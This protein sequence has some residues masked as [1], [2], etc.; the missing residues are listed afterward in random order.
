MM[1]RGNSYRSGFTLVE[2]VVVLFI[3]SV[4]SA[5]AAPALYSYIESGRQISRMNT[6][7]TLYL[8]A[9]SQLTLLRTAGMLAGAAEGEGLAVGVDDTKV[10]YKLGEPAD[11]Q[12]TGNEE[13]V[14]FISKPTGPAPA[15]LML[16]LLSPVMEKTVLNDAILIELNIKTGV[17]LSVFYRDGRDDG[18]SFS[19]AQSAGDAGVSGP[20]GMGAAGYEPVAGIRGRKQG[21]YGVQNTGSLLDDAEPM[22][23]NIYDSKDDGVYPDG[24]LSDNLLFVRI[25]IPAVFGGDDFT[26]YIPGYPELDKPFSPSLRIGIDNSFNAALGGAGLY[27]ERDPLNAGGPPGYSIIWILD[28]V[29][30]DTADPVFQ[31]SYSIGGN[32]DPEKLIT[33]G[34]VNN[35]SGGSAESFGKHPYCGAGSLGGRYSVN[36]AR[37]LYNIRYVLERGISGAAYIQGADIDLSKPHSEVTNFTPIPGFTGAYNGNCFSVSNLTVSATGDA[38]LFANIAA[39][40]EVRN[41]ALANASVSSTGGSAGAVCGEL[42]GVISGLYVKYGGDAARS[43]ITGLINSGGVAGAVSDGGR[44][45]NSAFISPA[46]F[47]HIGGLGGGGNAS[48]GSG[49]A[50]GGIAGVN[51]GSISNVLFLALAP[52]NGEGDIVPIANEAAG[53]AGN[54]YYLSGGAIRPGPDGSAYGP[55]PGGRADYNLE[56]SVGPGIGKSTWELYDAVNKTGGYPLPG[57]TKRAGLEA[58][59]QADSGD[60]A[61]FLPVYPYPFLG[62]LEKAVPDD[63]GWPIAGSNGNNILDDG[64]RQR[65]AG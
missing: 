65:E 38:G 50:A 32:L 19:Y 64:R 14:C 9:Q 36:S 4:L 53:I 21:Y 5:I 33:A 48:G 43:Y 60:A 13:N 1:K 6:A 54:A 44:I 18:F 7:R 23:I 28:Y 62:Q 47:S 46:P 16:D 8:A 24:S 29:G 3:A 22:S 41:L 35:T 30:G 39:G 26:A 10:Y 2:L 42:G 58:E 52:I 55:L 15:G 25:T 63:P 20:R 45:E 40:G 59:P 11:W 37:H 31:N 17:V 34:I 49:G 56:K 61:G 51:G 12:D 27:I 57:W